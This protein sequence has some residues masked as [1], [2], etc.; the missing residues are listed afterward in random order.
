MLLRFRSFDHPGLVHAVTT[1]HGG[2]SAP[3]HASLNLSF[4]RPDELSAVRENRRR[5]YRELGI[6]SG[7]VVQVGQ[8][9]GADVLV[10]GDE[11]A[12]HGALD[13]SLVLPPADAIVTRAPD[14][15][16]LA[17]F[18]DCTPLLFWDP[19]RRAVGIAHAGWQGTVKR[20]A[21]ATV[22]A[23][24]E[25][26]GTRP[27]ELQVVVGPSAGPCCYNVG[28]QVAD[29]ALAAY[30]G[31]D[32]VIVERGGRRFFDLW[33][34]NVHALADAGV[35]RGNVEVAALCTIDQH[36]RFFSHRAAH[37]QTGRFAA[38]IGVRGAG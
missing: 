27:S 2:V 6:P 9:H 29:A 24:A 23:M 34:A 1:R 8:V 14:L 4:S 30:P 31:R 13:R 17:C 3:P 12:G 28:A 11:H 19:V 35:P 7:R 36:E 38:L 18:A 10:A 16:L 26:F 22:Q 15:F 32:D 21:V 37:G 33:A 5:V 25:A 20:I